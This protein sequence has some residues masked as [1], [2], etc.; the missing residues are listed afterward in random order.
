[1]VLTPSFLPNPL[2][3]RVREFHRGLKPA[4][5]SMLVRLMLRVGVRVR[6]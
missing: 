2:R 1:M 4:T 5:Q 6:V 3:F